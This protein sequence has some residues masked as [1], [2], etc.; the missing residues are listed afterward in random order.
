MGPGPTV[1][2][3]DR[4]SIRPEM[5]RN[6]L[7]FLGLGALVAC[8][9]AANLAREPGTFDL[10]W[11]IVR[12]PPREVTVEVTALGP[13]VQTI[14]APGVIE[15]IEEAEIASQ[16]VGRVVAVEVEEGDTVRR[17][18]LLVKLDETEARA[19]LDSAE[20]RIERL[21]S[22]IAHASA[23]LEKADRDV[24]QYGQ[25]AGRGFSSPTQLADARSSVAMAEAGLA[26]SRHELVESEALRLTSRQDLDRTEIR[27]PI[28]GVVAGLEVEVGE[29]VIAGTTN[30]PGTVLMT[31]SDPGRLR[32]RADVDET[33]VPLVLPG[34]PARIYLQADQRD[35]IEGRVDRVAA[36]GKPD[37]EVVVF[38]TLVG[39]DGPHPALRM[40]MTA[41]IEVEVSRSAEARGVPVQA[42][43][44]RRLKDL[45]DTPALRSWAARNAPSPGERATEAEARY[46][47]IVFVADGEVARA[48][49]VETGLSDERRVEIVAGLADDDRV[50]V[51]PFRALDE[52]KDGDPIAPAAPAADLGADSRP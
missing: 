26:M 45:P 17:G 28:D 16:I 31:V 43:V 27:A 18:D 12:R 6:L 33:D 19:R 52:L 15:A 3:S 39:V 30:L 40:G 41:T 9:A 21:R 4:E 35:P 50:I 37:G 49:P 38:E 51:G 1:R 20:A 10:D 11:Q 23:E 8:L 29:V 22:A 34:Q 36:K 14:T 7:V 47:K 44:H 48:R 46:V 13:I 5:R 2:P 25:L 32:A 42:V 24:A